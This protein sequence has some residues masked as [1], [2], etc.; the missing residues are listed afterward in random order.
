MGS[1]WLSAVWKRTPELDV[2]I[3]ML[4]I[5]SSS[6]KSRRFAQAGDGTNVKERVFSGPILLSEKSE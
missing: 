2:G 6:E 1:R 3:G 4:P 5:F